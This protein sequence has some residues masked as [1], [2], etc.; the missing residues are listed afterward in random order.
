[1]VRKKHVKGFITGAI[2]AALLTAGAAAFAAGQAPITA[3][4][5]RDISII[6]RGEE[7]ELKD[8]AG[9]RVYPILYEGTTY[10]PL[11]GISQLYGEPV[12]WDGDARSAIIGT[13]DGVPNG[14]DVYM[15]GE[16]T[17][18]TFPGFKY[19][20]FK[21]SGG[22]ARWTTNIDSVVV[23]SAAQNDKGETII[24]LSISGH[25]SDT[26]G[27]GAGELQIRVL[28][29]DAYGA[30]V[31]TVNNDLSIAASKDGTTA[32]GDVSMTLGKKAAQIRIETSSVQTYLF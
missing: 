1:M 10:V 16:P 19:T 26:D 11:R 32:S 20:N 30:E 2:S 21:Y 28:A 15:I 23:K 13:K 29:F 3:T 7:R 4:Q 9:N 12:S 22:K 5:D 18:F 6:F 25:L 14:G 17:P 8:A 24:R 27:K 31:L